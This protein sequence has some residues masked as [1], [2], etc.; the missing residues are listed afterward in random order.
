MIAQAHRPTGW[1]M[2][3]RYRVDLLIFRS[4]RGDKDNYEKS[5]LDSVNPRRA[6]YKGKGAKRRVVRP[7]VPGV[8]WL[9]DGRVYEG[10]QAIRD[11]EPM[12]AR[13]EV[14]VT[15]LPVTCSRDACTA[16]TLYPDEDGRCSACPVKHRLA[17]PGRRA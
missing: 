10:S 4:E 17:K 7:A 3:C 13:L 14:T 1:P 12:D 11:V 5:A 9:D 15:A 2:R 8:L 16:T 6:K